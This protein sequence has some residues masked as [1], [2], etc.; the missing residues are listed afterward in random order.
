MNI[1]EKNLLMAA[2]IGLF[3]TIVGTFLKITHFNIGLL[4]GNS[5]L[6]ISLL[7]TF[8][9]W[10]LVFIDIFRNS[11]KN[12]LLWIIGMLFFINIT[13]IIYLIYKRK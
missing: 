6:L 5:V 3:M 4:I 13:P 1:Q 11:T 12:S 10:I 9:V 8:I 2:I 7:I